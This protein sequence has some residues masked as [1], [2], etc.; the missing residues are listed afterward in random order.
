MSKLDKQAFPGQFA[1]S[2]KPGMTM[3]EYYAGL[4]MQGLIQSMDD[5]TPF[6]VIAR[7]AVEAADALIEEMNKK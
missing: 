2:N 7:D 6:E 3:R 1:G 5:T 4:A